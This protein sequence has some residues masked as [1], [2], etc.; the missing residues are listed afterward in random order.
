M[1]LLLLA[2]GLFDGSGGD[3]EAIGPTPDTANSSRRQV[4]TFIKRNADFVNR[5]VGR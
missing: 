1:L 4:A 3:D 5:T 2:L